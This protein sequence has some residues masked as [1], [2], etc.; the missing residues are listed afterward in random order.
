MDPFALEFM[1]IITATGVTATVFEHARKFS[2][3]SKACK[4]R[5]WFFVLEG[6]IGSAV[7]PVWLIDQG[8]RDPLNGFVV[9]SI[10]PLIAGAVFVWRSMRSDSD[11]KTLR[12]HIR[13][14]K[15]PVGFTAEDLALIKQAN[16]EKA[17][18]EKGYDDDERQTWPS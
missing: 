9:G 11:D 2:E 6:L 8:S 4:L 7:L 13:D 5:G 17:S 12:Q 1:A 3:N 18:K 10:F 14:L 15:S 16:L